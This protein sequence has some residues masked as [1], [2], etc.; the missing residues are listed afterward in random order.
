[1]LHLPL[2]LFSD[3]DKSHLSCN[4]LTH[5]LSMW[6]ILLSETGSLNFKNFSISYAAS[7]KLITLWLSPHL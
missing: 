7:G 4:N 2:I 3:L 6:I 5:D 1:M